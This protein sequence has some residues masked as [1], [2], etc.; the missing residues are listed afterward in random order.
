MK[1]FKGKIFSPFQN[2]LL[3]F[4]GAF[5]NNSA[6]NEVWLY[7]ITSSTWRLILHVNETES[8]PYLIGHSAHMTTN[9]NGSEVMLIFFGYSPKWRISQFV[10]EYN[11]GEYISVY[12]AITL[13]LLFRLSSL[14]VIF[15]YLVISNQ[16]NL[17]NINKTR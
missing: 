17:K 9:Y 5:L 16:C 7:N 3:I 14:P 11:I 4:G 13:S 6:T 10:F 12:L 15:L 8:A 1:K 2:S